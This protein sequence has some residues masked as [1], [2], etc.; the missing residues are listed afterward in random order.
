MSSS[1]CPVGSLKIVKSI[2][3]SVRHSIVSRSEWPHTKRCLFVCLVEKRASKWEMNVSNCPFLSVALNRSDDVLRKNIEINPEIKFVEKF[4][5]VLRTSGETN[6]CLLLWESCWWWIVSWYG[7]HDT[8]LS[9]E[10]SR[11]NDSIF[12]LGLRR[13]SSVDVNRVPHCWSFSNRHSN[14]P[15]SETLSCR[16]GW[17]NG[18]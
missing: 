13:I 17:L 4:Q 14:Q 2:V 9:G 1:L 6:C 10:N 7:W 15:A 16:I 5:R 8:M 11:L 18:C 3:Y 12:G